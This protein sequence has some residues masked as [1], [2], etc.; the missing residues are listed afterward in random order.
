MYIAHTVLGCYTLK[1]LSLK[2]SVFGRR[3]Q[4]SF[5]ELIRKRCIKYL[6]NLYMSYHL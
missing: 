1:P 6:K 2:C 5:N 3:Y 4:R